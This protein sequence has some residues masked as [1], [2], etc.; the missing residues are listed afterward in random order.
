M[1]EGHKHS[2]K[3]KD[4]SDKQ[5]KFYRLDPDWVSRSWSHFPK[6]NF[7]KFQK[8]M[9][10]PQRASDIQ[11]LFDAHAI[12][13]YGGIPDS[14]YRRIDNAENQTNYNSYGF[15]RPNSPN[16][17]RWLPDDIYL[18]PEADAGTFLHE[19]AHP[20]GHHRDVH[21]KNYE[22]LNPQD[23]TAQKIGRT[24]IGSMLGIGGVKTLGGYVKEYGADAGVDQWNYVHGD[25]LHPYTTQTFYD[26]YYE[27]TSNMPKSL[28]DSLNT[29]TYKYAENSP[30][31]VYFRKH[32]RLPSDRQISPSGENPLLAGTV[33]KKGDAIKSVRGWIKKSLP[34]MNR[35]E[36]LIPDSIY[37][38]GSWF[39]SKGSY[40]PNNPIIQAGE[41]LGGSIY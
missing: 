13:M 6:E 11:N 31:A 18:S 41:K 34:W 24:K 37:K 17:D 23:S 32:G 40:D 9:K 4:L 27:D 38:Q 22:F 2:T 28:L 36:G 19:G 16:P 25:S 3:R 14:T 8:K 20:F 15:Y 12:N 30:E 10:K 33:T 35:G 29:Q 26:K 1:A 21:N 7:D 39:G 5:R